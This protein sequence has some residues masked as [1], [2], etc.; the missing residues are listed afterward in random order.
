[1]VVELTEN[2]GGWERITSALDEIRV[3][4]EENLAFFG[5]VF[6]QLDSLCVSLLSREQQLENLTRQIAESTRQ[7][8]SS[9]AVKPPSGVAAA[10]P[11]DP[12]LESVLAQFELLQQDRLFHRSETAE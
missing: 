5:G 3:C 7:A 4:H 10:A 11:G 8:E 1:M 6:D 9:P 2:I 12:V